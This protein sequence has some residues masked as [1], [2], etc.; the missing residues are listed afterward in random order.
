MESSNEG[1]RLVVDGAGGDMI[2]QEILTIGVNLNN[3][4]TSIIVAASQR[5]SI[6]N[7]LLV[8]NI[9]GPRDLKE[10]AAIESPENRMK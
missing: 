4:V 5:G 2:D 3:S 6:E 7:H 9:R 8:L 10:S 1:R